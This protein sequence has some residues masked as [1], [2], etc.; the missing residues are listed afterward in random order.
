LTE[1]HA[2]DDI[3]QSVA[4]ASEILRELQTRAG[5]NPVDNRSSVYRGIDGDW[6]LNAKLPRYAAD[7]KDAEYVRPWG[8]YSGNISDPV[9]T[10]STIADWW[11]PER[12]REHYVWLTQAAGTSDLFVQQYVDGK[13]H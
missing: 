2:V 12:L 9:S 7:P 11:I 1:T 13:G 8:F 6:S 3:P 10:L 4:D 5:G